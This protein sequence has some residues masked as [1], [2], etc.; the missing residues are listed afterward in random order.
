MAQYVLQQVE[1]L[2]GSSSAASTTLAERFRVLK[3]VIDAYV[4]GADVSQALG[5]LIARF[6]P[7]EAV[8]VLH[9]LS[10]SPD[11]R[12]RAA[13]RRLLFVV[14]SRLKWRRS[15]RGKRFWSRTG[16]LVLRRALRLKMLLSNEYD[17]AVSRRERERVVLV[18][19]K[20]GSMRPYS[21]TALLAATSFLGAVDG[22]VVF[23]SNVYVFGGAKR[24]PITRLLD[25]LLGIEF[26]GYTDA[27]SAIVVAS[28]LFKPGKM[29][30]IS[31][32]RQT[33]ASEHS[34]REALE[35]AVKRGWRVYVLAP[36][37]VDKG[38][39]ESVRGVK[40]A[41]FTDESGLVKVLRR[42]FGI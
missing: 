22:I 33:V 30:I 11:P 29:V 6:K 34:V 27:S 39:V 19:D 24:L 15:S 21:V 8:E 17:I 2:V 28:R 26:E 37:T 3:E 25:T 5:S 1:G 42:I 4:S 40:V 31:D 10:H 35:L 18:L 23:D 16:R 36:P 7:Y 38:Q 20:S 41:V 32:L 12:V 14:L 13:A 9:R